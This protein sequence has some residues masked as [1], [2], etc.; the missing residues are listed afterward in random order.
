M[1]DKRYANLL[2]ALAQFLKECATPMTLQDFV[3]SY[4]EPRWIPAANLDQFL[5]D[6]AAGDWQ[7]AKE[8]TAFMAGG[9][10]C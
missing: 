2:A 1:N 7:E 8:A 3:S 6:Y 9:E 5:T 10:S 4:D